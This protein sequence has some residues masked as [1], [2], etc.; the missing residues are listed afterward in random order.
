MNTA[1][2]PGQQ[3]LTELVHTI[4]HR[5]AEFLEREGILGRCEETVT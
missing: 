4:S 2:V 1:P 5:V 3:E